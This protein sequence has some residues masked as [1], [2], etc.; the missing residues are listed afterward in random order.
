M[1]EV[2]EYKEQCLKLGT[3]HYKLRTTITGHTTTQLCIWSRLI[4]RGWTWYRKSWFLAPFGVFGQYEISFPHVCSF[5]ILKEHTMKHFLKTYLSLSRKAMCLLSM[6]WPKR[7]VNE[8]L[9]TR[10]TV[11]KQ[12]KTLLPWLAW[13]RKVVVGKYRLCYVAER[14]WSSYPHQEA[15][16]S[17]AGKP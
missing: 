2:V 11:P 4:Q 13:W 17:G 12:L 7:D 8:S 14:D 16:V 5:L 9:R 6:S 3:V 10:Y 15:S 1:S